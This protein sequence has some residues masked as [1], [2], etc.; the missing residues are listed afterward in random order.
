M[1]FLDSLDNMEG[2]LYLSF[3]IKSCYNF[4]EFPQVFPADSYLLFEFIPH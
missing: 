1:T 4:M 3:K 2:Y